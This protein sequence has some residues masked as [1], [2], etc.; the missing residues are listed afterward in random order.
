LLLL[1]STTTLLSGVQATADTEKV[2]GNGKLCLGLED[3]DDGN[4]KNGDGYVSF[5]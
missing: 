2:C 5:V 3:C 4:S 1:F